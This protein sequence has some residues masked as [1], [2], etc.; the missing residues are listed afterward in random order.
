MRS[1]RVEAMMKKLVL[2]LAMLLVASVAFAQ[3][4]DTHGQGAS[5]LNGG[6]SEAFVTV[7]GA[8]PTPYGPGLGRHDLLNPTNGSPLGC[9][10]CHLPHTAPG[11]GAAFLWAWRNLPTGAVATY[12]TETNSGRVLGPLAKP[13]NRAGAARSLLCLSCHDAATASS[14]GV[15]G[16]FKLVDTVNGSPSGI[17]GVSGIFP[18]DLT[19]QHPVDATVPTNADYQLAQFVS[20]SLSNSADSATAF[21]GVDTQLPLWDDARVECSSC[22][23]QHNDYTTSA[24]G[25]GGYPFLRWANANGTALCRQCHNK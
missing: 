19:G 3:L 23:D 7:P 1:N 4:T 2:V 9:E 11:F 5:V 24:P 22:H 10:T 17:A 8:G 18:R 15:V 16:A 21:I 13:G 20:G 12:N 25:G 14:N 6:I